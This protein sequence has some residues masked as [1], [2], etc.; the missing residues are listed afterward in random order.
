MLLEDGESRRGGSTD[1]ETK[2][3]VSFVKLHGE[4]QC[5]PDL[6][7]ANGMKPD[8]SGADTGHGFLVDESET[9]GRLGA[10][11]STT[12]DTDQIARQ[13]EEQDRN[14]EEI[15]QKQGEF[16]H[17]IPEALVSGR[18]AVLLRIRMRDSP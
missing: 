10:V 7:Y 9:L 13:E 15:V 8:P 4:F 11:S 17:G 18:G 16:S 3:S 2:I 6:P 5:D 14:E 1:E 12:P